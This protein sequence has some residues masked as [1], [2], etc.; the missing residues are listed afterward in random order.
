MYEIRSTRQ[1]RKTFKKVAKH[2]DFDLKTLEGVIDK[3]A[4]GGKLEAK[5]KDH[6]LTGTLKNFRECHVKND[7]L[8]MYQKVDDQLILVLVDLGSHSELFK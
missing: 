5:H 1:Y 4:K 7:I 3:I 6:Q 8:L 2:K